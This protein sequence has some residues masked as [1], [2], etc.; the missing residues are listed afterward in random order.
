MAM[1]E[2][3]NLHRAYGPRWAVQAVSFHVEAGEVVG[4][5]GKNGAGKTTTMRMLTGSLGATVGTARIGGHDISKDPRAVQRIVGYL[6]EHPPLYTDMTVRSYL[7]FCARLKRATDP[8]AAVERVMKRVQLDDVAG[9]LIQNLSKGYRQ[10]VGIAQALVHGPQVLILDEPTSGLDPGQRREVKN[11]V[12]QLGDEGTTV[13]LSTH[14][15]GEVEDVCDRVLILH[16]GRLVAPEQVAAAMSQGMRAHVVVA[17][18]SPELRTFLA[19]IPG[20]V[21][22][23]ESGGRYVIESEADVREAVAK[24]AVDAGLLELAADRNLEDVFHAVTIGTEGAS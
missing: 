17:R 16:Q 21:R 14:V 7:R 10:R 8:S 22:V 9:R 5:L 20:V 24:I 1:I 2:V 6:P 23:E 19:A 13:L 18:P 15:L 3:E 11:L 12:R 4:F